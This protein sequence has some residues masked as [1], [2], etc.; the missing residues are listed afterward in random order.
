MA[1]LDKNGQ[2][3]AYDGLSNVASGLAGRNDKSTH[4][5]WD[6]SILTNFAT[7]DSAYTGH[8]MPA[9]IVDLPSEE[10]CAK[11]RTIKCN[12]AEDIQ[13]HELEVDY[14]HIV[15]EALLWSRLYGGAGVLMLTGQDLEKPFNINRVQKGTLERPD[16][17]LLVFDRYDLSGM[18]FNYL[19]PLKDNYLEPTDY[20]IRG[21]A[22]KVHHT[23]IVKFYGSRLPKRVRMQTQGWGDSFLRK[24]LSDVNDIISSKG[25]IS[26]LMQEAN[27]DVFRAEELWEKLSTQQD[28][29][30]MNRYTNLNIMKSSMQ[31]IVLDKS[32]EYDRK[33]LNLSGVPDT[34]EQF[35]I[36]LAAASGI[37]MTKL[38]GTSAK[39]MSATGEGDM[40]NYYDMLCGIQENH[41]APPLRM[42]DQVLCRSAIGSYPTDYDYDWNP[43]HQQDQL[44]QAQVGKIK[45]DTH[46]VYMDAGIVNPAQV[47][48]ELQSD[49][50]Y[51]FDDKDIEAVESHY[52][53]PLSLLDK[54]QVSEEEQSKYEEKLVG[55]EG[56]VEPNITK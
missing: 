11:W 46:I 16:C 36:L 28:E 37:P 5:R 32:E 8:W 27:V 23:H 24:C 15:S 13:R 31:A 48:R 4:N 30:I 21:G 7:I 42:L 47:Q 40:N 41:I 44:K 38:F 52:D 51:Q 9:R 43:I 1:I 3:I 26:N 53:D 19:N 29:A 34:I 56:K 20:I 55:E 25:G 49:E 14:K 22:V 33:T 2:A 50:A 10:A 45:A 54:E 35:M 12:K 17:G 18:N 39:G 6:Y